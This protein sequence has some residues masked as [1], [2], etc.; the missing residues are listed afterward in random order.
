MIGVSG[1]FAAAAG[2]EDWGEGRKYK[3]CACCYD[4]HHVLV[5]EAGYLSSAYLTRHSTHEHH[6]SA[7]FSRHNYI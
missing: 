5:Q 2:W 4:P 7:N 3:L 1:V 6:H